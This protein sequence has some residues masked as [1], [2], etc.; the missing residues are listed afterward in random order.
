MNRLSFHVQRGDARGG[1]HGNLLLGVLREVAQ[2]V[3][4]ARTRATGDEHVSI[5]ALHAVEQVLLLW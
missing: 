2:Q 4:F 5:C 3:R 1:T